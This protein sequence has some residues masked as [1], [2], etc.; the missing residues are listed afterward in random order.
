MNV[1]MDGEGGLIEIQGTA[2]NKSFSR[3]QLSALLD[4]AEGG[5]E[6]IQIA[7]RAALAA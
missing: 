6:Q 5:I 3:A 1:V 4:L 2:E 7:Q